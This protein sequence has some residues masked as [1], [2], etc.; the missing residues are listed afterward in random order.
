VFRQSP[1]PFAEADI[2]RA[3]TKARA[4]ATQAHIDQSRV[5]RSTPGRRSVW[6]MPGSKAPRQPSRPRCAIRR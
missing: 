2:T 5:V 6:P 3:G 1:L 4:E